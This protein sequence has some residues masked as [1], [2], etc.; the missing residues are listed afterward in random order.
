LFA[1]RFEEQLGKMSTAEVLDQFQKLRKDLANTAGTLKS[2]EEEYRKA[3]AAVARA[4]T[5]LDSPKDPFL[6][7]A[8][9]QGQAEKQ[10][11]LAEFR[12]EAGLDRTTG[13]MGASMGMMTMPTNMPTTPMPMSMTSMMQMAE[14]KK[15][16]D[17]K[18]EAG[19][20]AAEKKPE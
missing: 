2:Q 11:I 1:L 19:E 5:K 12:K 6:R 16:D 20:K 18:L 14:P 13:P 15:S 10:K 8:E 9:E 7:T 17:K 4:K 3:V